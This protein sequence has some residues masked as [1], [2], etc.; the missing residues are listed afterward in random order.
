MAS[1]ATLV[2][3]AGGVGSAA[4]AQQ[5]MPG[6]ALYGM[7]RGIETVATNVSVGDDSRGRRELEHAMTRLAEVRSLAEQKADPSAVNSTLNDFSVQARRGVSRLVASYQQDGD[8][9][10]LLAVNTFLYDAASGIQSVARLLPTESLRAMSEAWATIEA[11]T[12][13]AGAACPKCITPEAISSAAPTPGTTPVPGAN[14][15][16]SVGI[17]GRP[18]SNPT[19][20]LATSGASTA[21][22][23]GQP[24]KDATIAIT[25]QPSLPTTS[26]R[27]TGQ[28]TALPTGQPTSLPTLPT[29]TISGTPQWPFPS[30]TF[31]TIT[32]PLPPLVTLT[33]GLPFQPN[34]S[35]SPR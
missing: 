14:A 10:S 6:D 32:L 3:L 35:P 25:P 13:H 21:P 15:T 24:T 4:A 26:T 11:L 28:P 16:P 7:K 34:S 29:P 22:P 27:P 17:A 9:T 5:A 19:D 31:P 23:T 8:E 18:S 20:P 2:L 30:L 12:K 33:L 1:T